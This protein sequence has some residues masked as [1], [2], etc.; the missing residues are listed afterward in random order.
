MVAV[1]EAMRDRGEAARDGAVFEGLGAV[2]AIGGEGGQDGEDFG[3]ARGRGAA[4][5]I[6][7]GSGLGRKVGG[8]LCGGRRFVIGRIAVRRVKD[9]FP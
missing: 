9:C 1:L 3:D 8:V 6:L 5:A 7:W 2:A 4:E